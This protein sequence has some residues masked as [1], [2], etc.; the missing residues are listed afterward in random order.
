M[1]GADTVTTQFTAIASEAIP[2]NRLVVLTIRG[3]T[4][5]DDRIRIRLATEGEQPD[6]IAKREL[7]EGEE[8]TVRIT[9]A[10][11]WTVEAGE[12]IRA[13]VQVG[14]G[15][16]GKIVES[17]L[18][19]APS[20]I[21]Y[22]IHSAKAGELVKY[23]R[24]GGGMQGPPGPPGPQGPAGP[25]GPKGDKGDP[26]AKGPKGDPGADGFPTET[27]WNDLVARVDALEGGGG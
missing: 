21:G 1:K 22:S 5:E 15:E 2:A 14:T 6:F 17:L 11:T 26:G 12:N 19:D 4:E 25:A 10:D 27:Q 18:D 20:P 9:G 8:V 3:K 7:K 24:E 16:D 23:V 13:G